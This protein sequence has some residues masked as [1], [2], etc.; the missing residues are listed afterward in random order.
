MQNSSMIEFCTEQLAD[1]N[2]KKNPASMA[3]ARDPNGN[4]NA[5]KEGEP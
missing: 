1:M 3:A 4:V 5:V 2:E